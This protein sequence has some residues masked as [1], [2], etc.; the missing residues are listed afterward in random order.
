MKQRHKIIYSLDVLPITNNRWNMGD[1][2]KETVYMTA[3]SILYSHLW[4][5]EIELY[6]DEIGFKFLYMLPCAVTKVQNDNRIELWMKS[7]IKAMELQTKPFVHIDTDIFIKKKI[8]FSFDDVIVERKEDTYEV[9]YKKQVELFNKYT[10]RLPYWH[11]DLGYSFNCG[12]FGFNDLQ[13]RD[14]YLKSYY[15]L[16]NIYIENQKD[17]DVLKKEGY[18][19]CIL[20]E[21]YTL[22][23][24]LNYKNN[25]P[26]TLLKGENI[27]EHG[28]HA[29][30]I[31]YSH[32]FGMKKYEKYVVE[33]IELRLSKIFPY[34][35]K[36]I[37][38]ALEK[39]GVIADIPQF[40][41]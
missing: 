2:L 4:Y 31:G 28:K 34:W 40:V 6:V 41:Y 22:A 13:L 29:D 21:Q 38:N 8:E 32:F 39:E 26:T 17:F 33:E 9:H 27:T 24:L 20:I 3:L 10:C 18:E 1:K 35:Y 25:P 11:S 36:Q 16:E 14:E 15:D 37:K 12:I 7:K 5:D 30:H 19:T 23:S